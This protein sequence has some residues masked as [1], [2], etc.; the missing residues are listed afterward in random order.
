MKANEQHKKV[1]NIFDDWARRGR[2]EGME[3]GHG[4]AAREGFSFL[5]PR[6]GHRYLD[7]GCGNGYT[8][9][10]AAE[11]GAQSIGID[12]SP[13]MIRRAK[14][15]SADFP[16]ARFEVCAFPDTSFEESSF[17]RIFSMETFYYLPDLDQALQESHHLLRPEGRMAVIVDFYRE[18]PASHSWPED[19]G[20]SFDLRSEEEW[21][22]AFQR[23]GFQEVQRTHFLYP[24]NPKKESWKS[25]M[26]SLLV[27]AIK[28]PT[29]LPISREE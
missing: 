7:I 8:V 25:E 16:K 29:S 17:D 15:L 5:D 20:C 3:K 12:I 4:P 2:A 28:P 27:L 23:A 1:R 10:W 6:P 14:E 26:G 13:E 24:P 22:N 19:L 9:R 11:A 18:N 21:E